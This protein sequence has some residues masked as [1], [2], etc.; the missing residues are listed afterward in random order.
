M[1]QAGVKRLRKVSRQ[2]VPSR[3]NEIWKKTS[4][5]KFARSKKFRRQRRLFQQIPAPTWTSWRVIKNAQQPPWRGAKLI[6]S[7]PS[8]ACQYY[9]YITS[10]QWKKKN[11]RRDILK[12]E[13][14]CISN[15]GKR[16]RQGY[17]GKRITNA[18][19]LSSV[20]SF[21]S[22]ISME[23]RLTNSKLRHSKLLHQESYGSF[24]EV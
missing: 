6:F 24:L 3:A 5:F 18:P 4:V 1:I 8:P 14:S 9:A 11:N 21:P 13:S 16:S 12:N 10:E 23:H 19:T 22:E 2:H 17:C 7:E 15:G 20:T